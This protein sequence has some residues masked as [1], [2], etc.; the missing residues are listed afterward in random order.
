MILNRTKNTV[1]GIS[2]GILNKAASLLLPFFVRTVL[3]QKIGIEYAGLSGLFASVLQVLNLAELG[4]SEAVVHSMYKPIAE[5]DKETLCALLAFYRKIYFVIGLLIFAA[6]LIVMPF[7]TKLIYGSYPADINLYI[8]YLIYLLNTS[9]SY[10]FF[11]YKLSILNG[12]Q[13]RDKINNI[14]TITN[15]FLNVMQ[16]ILLITTKSYYLYVIVIPLSTLLNNLLISYEVKKSFPQYVCK[17]TV[18]E[19]VK[20]NM[21]KKVSGLMIQKVCATT[22]N[23]FDSIFISAF[24]GLAVSAMYSNYYEIMHAVTSFMA[25]ITTSMLGGVGNGVQMKSKETNYTD[26][27]RFNF[28]YMWISG[29]F[30]AA[31]LCLYQPFMQLWMGEAYM[32]DFKV[33]ILLC[34]Y[35]YVMKMGDIRS[36]YY[37]AAGLWWEGRWRAVIEAIINITLNAFLVQKMGIYGIILATLISMFTINFL[38]GSQ[39]VFRYYFGM[40]K[41]KEYYMLHGVYFVVMLLCMAVTYCCC[42]FC[43]EAMQIKGTFFALLLKMVVCIFVPNFILLI[44]YVRT[45]RYKEMVQWMKR[46]LKI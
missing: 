27:C 34:L 21:K 20:G 14:S 6:G 7:L 19:T 30:T 3:I 32:L 31:L 15:I 12:F 37:E 5:D 10:L 38:Y 28:M 23:T 16:M 44:T 40:E 42:E 43:V 45:K 4:F 33:V 39:F 41:L 22:R 17:G 46:R 13:R 36:V 29:W 8:L 11:G 18:S 35:F 1:R 25:I 26:M 24:L 2:T 9:I